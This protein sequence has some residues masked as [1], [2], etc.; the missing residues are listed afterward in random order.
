M[1]TLTQGQVTAL[2]AQ[3]AKAATY[4]SLDNAGALLPDWYVNDDGVVVYAGSEVATRGVGIYGQTPYNL[5]LV[6]LLKSAALSLIVNPSMTI[7]VLN[8]PAAWT[9]VYDI[10]SLADYLN[11][12]IIQNQ[13]QLALYDGAYQGLLDAGVLTGTEPARYIATFLQPAVRYGVDDVVSWLQGSLDTTLASAV[14]IAARQ[15]QY[16]IDFVDTYGTVLNV[17]P[18]S[19]ENDNTV[20]RDQIDQAV[21]DIIGDP[22]IPDIEYANV[23]AIIADAIATAAAT[24]N[25]GNI[26][27]SIPASTNDDGT[28]R[29]A[30]GSSQG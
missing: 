30:P 8:T 22:K 2:A 24:A 10:N 16:A 14:L 27:I 15:G 9:G 28:F 5:V 1:T 13:A 19:G 6:G 11:S 12:P 4:P 7:T 17:A 3:A 29:F 20:V 25:I 26:L 18:D 23:E 21:T